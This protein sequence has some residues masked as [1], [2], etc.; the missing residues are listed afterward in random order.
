M[1]IM[2]V[3]VKE[4]REEI[5]FRKALGA[6]QKE[7]LGQF[8]LEAILLAACGS[9]IGIGVG[10]GGVI[11]ADIFFSLATS[12]SIPSIVISVSVSSG[13]G[14]FFGVLPAKQAAKLDPIIALKN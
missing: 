4:R 10:L 11:I 6:S 12:I 3:S 2:L 9:M 8:M 13:F 5:G 14:F 1:N 7:I